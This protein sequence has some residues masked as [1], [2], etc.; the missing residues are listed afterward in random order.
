MDE[1]KKSLKELL[2]DDHGDVESTA[3]L[4]SKVP[5]LMRSI[6][7]ANVIHRLPGVKKKEVLIEVICEYIEAEEDPHDEAALYFTKNV[8]PT[9]IDTLI[10]VDTRKLRIK[11]EKCLSEVCSCLTM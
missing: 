1:L 5:L 11:A 2:S 10:S 7:Q 4:I 8:L 6:E 9:L 3:W